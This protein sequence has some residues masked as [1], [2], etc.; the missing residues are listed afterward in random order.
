MRYST[1]LIAVLAALMQTASADLNDVIASDFVDFSQWYST[2]APSEKAS[3]DA[4]TSSFASNVGPIY[5]DYTNVAA[6]VTGYNAQL[7]RQ[8]FSTAYAAYLDQ[9]Y[10]SNLNYWASVACLV[11]GQNCGSGNTGATGD[12]TVTATG[13]QADVTVTASA[14]ETVTAVAVTGETGDATQQL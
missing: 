2:A 8:S 11:D 5:T 3:F 12:V 13:D 14:Q 9:T 6:T 4:F 7:A 10:Y 1:T